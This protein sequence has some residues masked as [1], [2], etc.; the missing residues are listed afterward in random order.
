M[1]TK[2]P[3]S[4]KLQLAF[5]S[6]IL[7]LLV[8]GA[9]SYRGLVESRGSD[10]WVRHTREVLEN[11][12]N[13]LAAMQTVESN[14]RGYL[15]TGDESFLDTYRAGKVRTEREQTIVRNLTADNANQQRRL[16]ALATLA[17]QKFQLAEKVLRL[18][19]S[20]GLEAAEDA[21]QFGAGKQIMDDFQNLI[22]EMQDEELRLLRL[23]EANSTRRLDQAK[24]IL[25]LG[26]V[27]GLLVASCA[28]WSAYRDSSAR[29]FAEQALRDSEEKYRSLIHG[30]QDYAILM[31]GPQGEIRSWNPGA[32]RMTGCKFEEVSGQNYSR[33][34]SP[35]DVKLGRPEE[36]LR[37]AAAS[38]LYEEQGMRM[39]KSGGRF[40]VRTTYT[41]SRDLTGK[42]L[43][44]SVVSRDLSQGAESDAKY[45]GLLEA[46]PDA[47]VVVN[48]GGE[49]VLLNVQAEKQFG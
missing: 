29:G 47:M 13:L 20:S 41:A 7:A 46:A 44:F 2:S 28:G 27:L 32:E 16:D 3:L 22:G 11:L 42:L 19:R 36:L 34:F 23:R 37:M 17:T 25:I 30:V 33:F 35:E 26:T 10:L 39:R 5:G 12:Q 15:L 49:I 43:G 14:A 4:R 31:L 1:K 24:A 9:I 48:Q 6:A 45:R 40:L 21:I 18:R 8:V 38:G